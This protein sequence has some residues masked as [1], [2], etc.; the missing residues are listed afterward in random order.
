MTDVGTPVSDAAASP[1]PLRASWVLRL[2]LV[3]VAAAVVGYLVC[4]A[5]AAVVWVT[6]VHDSTSLTDAVRAG[7]LLWNAAQGAPVALA[8]TPISL[9]PWGL[10]LV[11]GL[12]LL[13]GA[14]GTVRRM[15]VGTY[16]DLGWVGGGVVAAAMVYAVLAA[17]AADF[18]WLPG[19]RVSPGDAALHSGLLALLAIATG[20]LLALHEDNERTGRQLFPVIP[21]MLAVVLRSGAL[22]ALALLGV[23]ALAVALSLMAHF[24]DSVSLMQSLAVG[25]GG[26]LGLVLLCLAYVPVLVVWGTA[27]VVGSGV[28]IGTGAVVSPF[29]AV[30]PPTS[31]PPVPLLAAI[32]QQATP[33]AWLAPVI[34]ICCGLAVG[35]SVGRGMRGAPRLLRAVIAVTACAFSGVLICLA[36]LLASGSLGEQRLAQLGPVPTALGM[37]AFV[38]LV[39]GAVPASLLGPEGARKTHLAVA[40]VVA[41]GE[42]SVVDA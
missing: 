7:G 19:A 2:V 24:D 3:A 20:A 30:T 29:V 35:L 42:V 33:F 9:M 11:C 36:G 34:A 13:V 18:T 40:P 15:D 8:A 16:R 27:Y 12:L 37:V 14:R 31:L 5:L 21:R 22:G 25:P 17:W 26:A 39:L 41:D 10:G 23:G 32:P 4:L 38:L 6:T 28:V 1:R